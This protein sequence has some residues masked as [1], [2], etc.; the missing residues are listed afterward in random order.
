[1]HVTTTD[2]PR[3]SPSRIYPTRST[4][5]PESAST[6]ERERGFTDAMEKE[7]PGIQVVATQFGMSVLSNSTSATENML[8]AHPELNGLFASAEPMSVGASQAL[9]SR[10]IAGKVKL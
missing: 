9:K 3:L 1:M 7:F 8:T 6:V 10:S 5:S 2:S 4:A